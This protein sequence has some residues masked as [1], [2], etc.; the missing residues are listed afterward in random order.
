[1]NGITREHRDYLTE[2]QAAT[3]LQVST[4]TLNR[5]RHKGKLAYAKI[6]RTLRYRRQDIDQFILDH[7]TSKSE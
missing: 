1:M 3:L 5:W 7:R 2:G 4:R 6:D